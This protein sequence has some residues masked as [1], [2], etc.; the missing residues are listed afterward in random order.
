MAGG[1]KLK[2]A[3]KLFINEG[4]YMK[5]PLL[6]A[7]FAMGAV[8]QI[9]PMLFKKS[10]KNQNVPVFQSD[11][12][13][14]EEQLN[15]KQAVQEPLL[16]Y[17][18]KKEKDLGKKLEGD[19][20]KEAIKEWC[21]SF[22]EVGLRQDAQKEKEIKKTNYCIFK[23]NQGQDI[24]DNLM[25]EVV[26][27]NNRKNSHSKSDLEFLR[28][29]EDMQ[30]NE[31]NAWQQ[32]YSNNNEIMGIQVTYKEP[33]SHKQPNPAY[34][35]LNLTQC[36]TIPVD[37]LKYFISFDQ[38]PYYKKSKNNE[39]VL[40]NELEN[41]A[42]HT[43]LQSLHVTKAVIER[44]LG[45]QS[46][47]QRIW[48]YTKRQNTHQALARVSDEIAQFKDQDRV[49]FSEKVVLQ[50]GITKPQLTHRE[51]FTRSSMPR[52]IFEQVKT[53]RE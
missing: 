34:A 2:I 13:I 42:Y 12:K 25:G 15:K 41:S 36:K 48:N 53:A 52:T 3:L 17:L 35:G 29:I 43:A 9:S 37:C 24:V 50:G 47:F 39:V 32:N 28:K 49:V 14:V 16:G 46:Y 1:G 4:L 31:W 22:K 51:V 33:V 10:H 7:I 8:H 26:K 23:E 38:S 19:E 27:L 18:E 6:V 11:V 45:N 20:R 5:K 21:D 40:A 30:K 44:D